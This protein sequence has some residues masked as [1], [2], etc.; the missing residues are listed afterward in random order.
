LAGYRTLF[1]EDELIEFRDAQQ[2]LF[3]SMENDDF[4]GSLHKVS[5]GDALLLRLERW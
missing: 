4:P 2:V 5:S 1:G 3:S